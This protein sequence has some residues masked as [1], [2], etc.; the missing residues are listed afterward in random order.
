[1]KLFDYF[2]ISISNLNK[3]KL[4]TTINVFSISI[5]VMLIVTLLSLGTGFEQFFMSK[6]TELNNLKHININSLEYKTEEELT[7][8]LSTT[9]ENGDINTETIFKEKPIT[10]EVYNKLK[11]DK[12]VEEITAKYESEVSEVI[13]AEKKAKE[14][15]IAYYDGD[16][17]LQSEF[18]QLE[19]KSEENE[20][21]VISQEPISYVYKGRSLTEEDKN[22]VMLPETFVRNT[23]Q[24]ED[25]SSVVGQTITLKSLIPDYE[26]TKTFEQTLTI[27]GVIDQ[28]F[29]QP[30]FLVSKDVMESFKNFENNNSIPLK[31]RGYDVVELSVKKI[32][33]VPT[34]T[35]Y[36]QDKLNYNTE[37]VSMVAKTINN[38]MLVLKISLSILGIIVIV[39]ASLEVINTMIMSIYERTKMIGL[40][41]A[42]GASK[43][44]IL[45]LFLVESATIGLFGGITGV[46]LAYFNLSGVNVVLDYISNYFEMN[47]VSI[48][49]Q[50][51]QLDISTSLFTIC[52]AISLSVLAGIYPA[53]KASKLDPIEA[54]KHE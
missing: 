26:N 41:R 31:D 37:S 24:V 25:V 44:D 32:A 16:C 33:D 42:T 51:T 50:I 6:L 17:Y 23:L 15:S 9:D 19:K 18:E 34:L 43:K 48:V 39:I 40:M 36:I 11:K 14:V 10:D 8:A 22:S 54:I 46:I 5:G 20:I 13:F 28:R 3:R 1:M 45:I 53:I 49:N 12:R 52:L 7:R 47:N 21:S 35:S 30:S 29:Y 4:R 27:V 2:K 38:I